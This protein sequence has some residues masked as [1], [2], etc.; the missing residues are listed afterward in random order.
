MPVAI[1]L[2][3]FEPPP[4]EAP[5]LIVKPVVDLSA[6]VPSIVELQAANARMQAEIDAL[7]SEKDAPGAWLPL[8]VAA[9]DANVPY[10]TAQGWA[11]KKKIASRRD[12]GRVFVTVDSLIDR[13]K[14]FGRR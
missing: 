3:Q 10:Q 11:A 4:G 12:G 7:R 9:F 14:R 13:L 5:E 6:A 8:N 2:E 1:I